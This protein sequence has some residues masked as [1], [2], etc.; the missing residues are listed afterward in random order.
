MHGI[1][2]KTRVGIVTIRALRPGD[3]AT[4]QSVFDR[5]GPRSRRL[6]FGHAVGEL[7]PADLERLA[8]VD[9]RHHVLVAYAAR[10]AV[11]V[12]QLARD[13]EPTSA[14]VAYAVADDWQGLGIG[15][16]LVKLLSADAAAVGIT[17]LHAT[18]QLDNRAS[19][20]VMRRATTVVSSRIEAG[21]LHV[22][23]LAA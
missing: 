21:E 23:G 19:L 3:T 12:A 15:T 16:A 1:P 18:M 4:V 13:E 10:R 9:G 8:R 11:G 5:L 22:V 7:T 14:E 17:R 20:S 6:R 2:V